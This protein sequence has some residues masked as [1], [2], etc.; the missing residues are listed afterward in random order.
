[1]QLGP[2]QVLDRLGEGTFGVVFRGRAPDGGAVAIK[3][4][5]RADPQVLGRFERERRL[6]VRLQ[7]AGFVRVLDWGSAPQGAYLVMPLLEGGTLEDRLRQGPLSVDVARGLALDLARA[8]RA[9]HTLGVL[10]RDLKPSNVLFSAS[11]SVQIADLGLAKELAHDDGLSQT[12]TLRGTPGYMAPEQVNDAKHVGP[13]ADVF[14]WGAV[15]YEC[16]SG[17][18]PFACRSAVEEIARATSG[19]FQPLCQ[20]RPQTPR[21]LAQVVE[22]ALAN[23]PGAR[24]ADGRELERRLLAAREP[25]QSARS[26][27]RLVG[28]AGLVLA[29]ALLAW[30]L[31]AG[32]PTARRPESARD[33]ASPPTSPREPAGSPPARVAP[34]RSP[35]P[36]PAARPS[37]ER[38][39]GSPP[40]PPATREGPKL[41]ALFDAR[42]AV[43]LRPQDPQARL[44]LARIQIEAGAR[45]SALECLDAL[46]TF[47]LPPEV[48]AW[49]GQLRFR[50]DPAGAG[51][52]LFFAARDLAPGGLRDHVVALLARLRR[53]RCA[54]DAQALRHDPRCR[55]V[56]GPGPDPAASERLATRLLQDYPT[57][58]VL[59]AYR[60]R[61]R[62]RQGRAE[63]ALHDLRVAA[64]LNPRLDRLWEL[65]GR[66]YGAQGDRRRELASYDEGLRH[67]PRSPQ[68]LFLRGLWLVKEANR[69][70]RDQRASAPAWERLHREARAYYQRALEHEPDH[71]LARFNLASLEATVLGR[72]EV[73]LPMFERL[74]AEDGDDWRSRLNLGI[75]LTRAGRPREALPHLERALAL[76]EREAPHQLELARRSLAA[77]RAAAR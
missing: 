14:S 33:L 39:G 73:A 29:G 54:P 30:L 31:L 48:H 72:G 5:K 19:H 60:A 17:Q 66:A 25:E 18:R 11:G 41:G 56:E 12:G 61:F 10:H 64:A 63:E 74:V 53:E 8:L 58:A 75:Q 1:M 32:A 67:S 23:E 44:R 38:A 46:P 24:P 21:A 9:A 3:L 71:R 28:A 13:A 16:L 22:A 4:L 50:P 27:P 70:P 42:R 57:A 26:R 69:I 49:R 51:V 7:G 43:E 76:I 34:A 35:T 40:P 55:E 2:Y 6:Q 52:D 20:L 62:R 36:P 37:G 65:V 15:I 68:L 45:G 47:D 77:A 59:W